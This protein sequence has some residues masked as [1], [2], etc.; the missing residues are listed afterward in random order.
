[1]HSALKRDGRP[2]YE[3]AREGLTVERAARNVTIMA[4]ELLSFGG[5]SFRMRVRCSKGTYIRTLAEDLCAAVGQRAHLGGLRRTAVTPFWDHQ[6]VLERSEEHTSELQS[7]MRIS[8][9]VFCLQK[10]KRYINTNMYMS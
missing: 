7:L 5:D 4:L 6:P 8:Y 10:K 3:L 2:L 1:M 9:A